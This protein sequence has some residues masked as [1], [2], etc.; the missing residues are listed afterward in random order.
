VV[1]VGGNESAQ[2]RELLTDRDVGFVDNPDF[3]SGLSSSLACGL[4]ALPEH[5]DGALVMLGDMPHITPPIIDRL[6]AAFNPTE[7]RAIC[8][9]TFG[10]KR[11]NPVLWSRRFFAEI[12]AL[13][14]DVGAKHLIGDYADLVAEVAMPDDA[15]LIDIDTPE[16]LASAR[17]EGRRPA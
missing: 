9:P 11:G 15:V 1:V 5:V 16:A 17:G 6:I 8:V 3:A 14:G 4:R 12:E 2:T 10:G 13:A 7:G